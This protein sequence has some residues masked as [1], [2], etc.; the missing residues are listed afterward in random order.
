[1][2]CEEY[3]LYCELN[4]LSLSLH[5]VTHLMICRVELLVSFSSELSARFVAR[6]FNV[7]CHSIVMRDQVISSSCLSC[8]LGRGTRLKCAFPSLLETSSM[9]ET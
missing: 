5:S 8:L 3:Q 1:M 9:Y 4:S 7:S 2:I 6:R